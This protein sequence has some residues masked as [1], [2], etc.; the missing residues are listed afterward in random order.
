MGTFMYPADLFGDP[1]REP[2]KGTIPAGYVRP[3][4]TGPAGETCAT[5]THACRYDHFS[6]C[7]AN[8]ARWTGGIKTDIRLRTPACDRWQQ[9]TPAGCQEG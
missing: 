9:A 7:G 3:P 2:I 5:C 8:R 1:V 4:G 6:K